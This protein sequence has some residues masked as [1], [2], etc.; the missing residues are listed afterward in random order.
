MNNTYIIIDWPEIQYYMD[1]PGFEE[2][3]FLINDEKG[4]EKFGSSAYFINKEWVDSLTTVFNL[5]LNI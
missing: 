3:A 4:L 5:N 1:K 2:N